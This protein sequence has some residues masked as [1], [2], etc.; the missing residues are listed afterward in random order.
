[1]NAGNIVDV[2]V[3]ASER[4][5]QQTLLL[6]LLEEGSHGLAD[7]KVGKVGQ[8]EFLALLFVHKPIKHQYVSHISEPLSDN[9]E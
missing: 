7:K 6:F 5:V 8:T 9:H 4:L 2:A 1:M 3:G